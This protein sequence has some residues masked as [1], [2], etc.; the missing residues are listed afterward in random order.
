MSEEAKASVLWDFLKNVFGTGPKRANMI[1]LDAFD[2]PHVQHEGLVDHFT[3]EELWNTI[4]LLS[5]DKAPSLDGF[6]TRFF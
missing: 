5:P 3:K 4:R 6:T 2:L 1:N